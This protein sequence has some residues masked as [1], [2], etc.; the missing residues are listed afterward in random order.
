MEWVPSWQ[1]GAI[2]KNLSLNEMWQIPFTLSD[3]LS[4]ATRLLFRSNIDDSDEDV[5]P[6]VEN[7]WLYDICDAR[8]ILVQAVRQRSVNPI[9]IAKTM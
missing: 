4:R 9:A 2:L 6:G 3:T 1:S 5:R 8:L 7:W